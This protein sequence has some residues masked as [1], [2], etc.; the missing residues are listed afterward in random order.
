[1]R[2]PFYA[3]IFSLFLI[4]IVLLPTLPFAGFAVATEPFTTTPMIDGSGY[5][6]V[7]LKSNGT[8]VA[9]GD[10]TYGNAM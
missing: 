5:H 1:M 8:V 9:T 3:R 2:K 4:A 6:T 10:N 7:G